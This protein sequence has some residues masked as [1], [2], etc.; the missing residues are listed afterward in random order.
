MELILNGLSCEIALVY[1][2]DNIICDRTFEEPLERL[3]P[4]LFQLEKGGLKKSNCRFKRKHILFL[5]LNLSNN[6]FKRDPE[7]LMQVSS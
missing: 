1:L 2:D 5:G 6:G 4:V 7:K 3:E